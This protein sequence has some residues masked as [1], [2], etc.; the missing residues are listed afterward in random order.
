VDS[1]DLRDLAARVLADT[2]ARLAA[3]VGA[4][5]ALR[6][7]VAR[8]E[9]EVVLAERAAAPAAAEHAG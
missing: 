1:D 4:W 8:S 6:H 9:A 2:D 5:D 3:A 7:R